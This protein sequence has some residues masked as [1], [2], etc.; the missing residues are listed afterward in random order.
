VQTIELT[1]T[2]LG[3]SWRYGDGEPTARIAGEASEL[4]LRL[5]SRPGVEL[6]ADW[7]QAVD[8]LGSPADR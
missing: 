4:F 2:D 6:P 8:S 1:A 3:R 5:M 7:A